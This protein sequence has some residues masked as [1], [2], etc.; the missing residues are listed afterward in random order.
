MATVHGTPT[1]A[2][3]DPATI[4]HGVLLGLADDD[5]AQYLLLAGR[6]GGQEAVGGSGASDELALRGSS[7]GGTGFVRIN[8]P[9]RFADD[10]WGAG[11]QPKTAGPIVFAP[12]IGNTGTSALGFMNVDPT[13]TIDSGVF[14]WLTLQ[15]AGTFQQTAAPVFAA[16]T[17]FQAVPKI[18]T[19]STTTPP[20]NVQLVS[21]APRISA[22]GAGGVVTAPGVT[23]LQ[24]TPTAEALQSD[25]GMDLTSCVAV[26]IG[27]RWNQGGILPSSRFTRFIGVEMLEPAT[28]PGGA[29]TGFA[30]VDDYWGLYCPDLTYAAVNSSSGDLA[31]VRSELSAGA[32]RYF[33]YHDG[34]AQSV[35]GG[36]VQIGGDLD[37]DGS[38]VGFYGT[39]PT[40]QSAAYTPSNVTPDRS[41]DADST[42]LDE[43]ADVL[44]TLIADLQA[45]GLVG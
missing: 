13:A 1:N 10:F 11:G 19:N 34:D 43:V 16:F 3:L 26:K 31:V 40:A 28:A 6:S 20:M 5:H 21:G 2:P 36:D 44:G 38:L 8:S 27:P 22:D 41:Y 23:G 14:F 33:L 42:T 4:D 35:L 45:V 18:W 25:D 32:S 17:L 12:D 29:K 39:A 9:V 37:H 15:A 7:D 24:F 30:Y